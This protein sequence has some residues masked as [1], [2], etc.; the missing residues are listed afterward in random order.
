LNEHAPQRAAPGG[1]LPRADVAQQAVEKAFYLKWREQ[2][3][4][5]EVDD[6]TSRHG[7]ALSLKHR[8]LLCLAWRGNGRRTRSSAYIARSI[9]A[10]RPGRA[11]MQRRPATRTTM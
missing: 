10:C 7:S 2:I 6:D 5:L 4:V 8:C 11:G 3:F 9:S 1:D